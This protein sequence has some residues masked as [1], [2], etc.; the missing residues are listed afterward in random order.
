MSIN[1]L[2]LTLLTAS[3]ACAASAQNRLRIWVQPV[4]VFPMGW[5]DGEVPPEQMPT[6]AD[7]ID[8]RQSV[9][10][11]MKILDVS[12]WK[13][14]AD[15]ATKLDFILCHEP[16]IFKPLTRCASQTMPSMSERQMAD[17]YV[18]LDYESAGSLPT[19]RAMGTALVLV[20][21]KTDAFVWHGGVM[22]QTRAVSPTGCDNLRDAL[23]STTGCTLW[24]HNH[25]NTLAHEL[26]Y[27]LGLRHNGTADQNLVYADTVDL[28][29]DLMADPWA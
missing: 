8:S 4:M 9:H 11:A 25:P 5:I 21:V 10:E 16:D 1:H 19:Q 28:T 15:M 27:C 13:Y 14:E 6:R 3:L 20:L 18:T 22:G 24:A 12:P 23:Y 7:A 2:A 26:G 29:L 17:L